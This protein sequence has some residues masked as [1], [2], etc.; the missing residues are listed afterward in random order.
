VSGA[1]EIVAGCISKSDRE[2]NLEIN[3]S[4]KYLE[5]RVDIYFPTEVTGM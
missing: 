2:V 1:S 3:G 5:A 4:I